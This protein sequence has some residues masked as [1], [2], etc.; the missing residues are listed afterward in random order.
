MKINIKALFH[1]IFS[2]VLFS[3]IVAT[4]VMAKTL[5]SPLVRAEH[6]ILEQTW[7]GSFTAELTQTGSNKKFQTVIDCNMVSHGLFLKCVHRTPD[8]EEVGVGITGF[9]TEEETF[10]WVYYGVSD[11]SMQQGT[12]GYF[13]QASGSITI[14]GKETLPGGAT[15]NFRQVSKKTGSSTLL[16]TYYKLG[17]GDPVKLYQIVFERQ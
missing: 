11:T 13:D 10:K 8:G 7:S 15:F 16:L 2:L 14:E 17:E 5:K 4:A 12:S 6:S 3:E 9:D 1:I